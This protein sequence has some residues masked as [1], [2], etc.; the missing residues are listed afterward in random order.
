MH[1]ILTTFAMA[2]CFLACKPSDSSFAGSQNKQKTGE[3]NLQRRS[4]TRPITPVCGEHGV[5]KVKLLSDYLENGV[6]GNHLIYAVSA[7]D[8]D[9]KDLE[10]KSAT[11]DFD[12]GAYSTIIDGLRYRLGDAAGEGNLNRVD[13]RDLFGNVGD[14][15]QFFRTDRT[16]DL[17]SGTK[18]IEIRI[19]LGGAQMEPYTDE[20]IA[21]GTIAT[22]LRFGDADPVEQSVPLH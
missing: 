18:D 16:I 21:R 6:P 5:T 12:I 13:G 4:S 22:F 14:E 15:F 1:H 11:V 2:L 3:G 9:G 8:C 19:E 7:V 17:T 20:D 10:K